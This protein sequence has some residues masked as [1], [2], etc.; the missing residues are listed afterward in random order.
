MRK[1]SSGSRLTLEWRWQPAIASPFVGTQKTYVFRR[2]PTTL[3]GLFT[4]REPQLWARPGARFVCA[5]TRPTDSVATP[6]LLWRV[7][8]CL[9][10][11]V[12]LSSR[13]GHGE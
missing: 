5:E 13:F 11:V 7:S 10:R 3:S 9:E 12:V 1:H 2:S 6:C 4:C 8:S